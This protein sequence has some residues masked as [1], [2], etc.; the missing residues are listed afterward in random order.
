MKEK[1]FTLVELLAVLVI[2]G[3]LSLLIVPQVSKYIK[4]TTNTTY[5]SY[6]KALSDAAKNYLIDNPS[7]MPEEA[8]NYVTNTGAI[9]ITAKTLISEGYMDS[10]KDPENSKLTCDEKSKVLVRRDNKLTLYYKVLLI[11]GDNETKINKDVE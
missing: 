11:C 10:M 8:Y 7:E 6:A 5:E 9:T 2:M 3:L 4:N 1:G